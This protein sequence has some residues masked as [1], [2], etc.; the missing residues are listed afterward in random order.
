MTNNEDKKI[1][2]RQGRIVVNSDIDIDI[3]LYRQIYNAELKKL[4]MREEECAICLIPF[5]SNNN[6]PVVVSSLEYV[7]NNLEDLNK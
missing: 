4:V 3:E 7:I 2:I 5:N 1:E 6:Y